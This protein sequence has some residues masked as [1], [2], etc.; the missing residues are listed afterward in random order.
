MVV[1]YI[2]VE[3]NSIRKRTRIF[4]VIYIY[5]YTY[6]LYTYIY[7]YNSYREYSDTSTFKARGKVSLVII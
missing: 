7:I 1:N 3:R 2:L 4:Y 6:V 5:I